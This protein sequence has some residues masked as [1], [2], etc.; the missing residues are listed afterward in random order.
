MPCGEHAT[1]SCGVCWC[2][3]TAENKAKPPLAL[4]VL[5]MRPPVFPALSRWRAWPADASPAIL[6]RCIPLCMYRPVLPLGFDGTADDQRDER[7]VGPVRG[8]WPLWHALRHVVGRQQQ[9]VLVGGGLLWRIS[10]TCRVR[11]GVGWCA[12]WCLHQARAAILQRPIVDTADITHPCCSRRV[13]CSTRVLSVATTI[14]FTT[15]CM[16]TWC[17]RLAVRQS[18]RGSGLGVPDRFW[19]LGAGGAGAAAVSAFL[20]QPFHR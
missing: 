4:T 1:L 2:G 3:R 7:A 16:V 9:P 5:Q 15:N 10:V 19:G 18:A 11:S 17:E 6:Q 12:T 8:H 13:A 14:F 20:C